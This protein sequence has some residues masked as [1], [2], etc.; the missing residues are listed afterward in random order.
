M[1]YNESHGMESPGLGD[2]MDRV[3]LLGLPCP[4]ISTLVYVGPPWSAHLG[5]GRPRKTWVDL[6][7]LRKTFCI[8]NQYREVVI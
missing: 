2:L 4:F 6:A 3:Y 7:H 1:D 8:M 5:S